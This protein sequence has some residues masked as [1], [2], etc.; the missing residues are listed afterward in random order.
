[1]SFVK[2][3]Y[4]LTH[5]FCFNLIIRSYYANINVFIFVHLFVVF[6]F[7]SIGISPFHTDEWR[8]EFSATPSVSSVV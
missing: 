8:P 1:M 4:K 7:A 3:I 5:L 2:I 6:E